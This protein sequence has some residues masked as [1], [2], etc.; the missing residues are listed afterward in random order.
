MKKMYLLASAALVALS[1][2]AKDL[3]LEEYFEYEAGSKLIADTTTG[4]DNLDGET[5]WSTVSN[6]N[7]GM[8]RFTITDAP[9][10]YEGY[11]GSGI[12]NALAF[13]PQ[14]QSGQ[15]V[16][17][18]WGHGVINDTTIYIAFLIQ[19]PKQD[20]NYDGS[21]YFMG[22][23]MEPSATS[24][25]FAGRLMAAVEAKD[26]ITGTPYTGQ[27]ISFGINKSSDGKAVWTNP[28]QKPYFTFDKTYLVV[29]KYH[30]GVINGKT[31]AEEKGNYDDEMW[32]YINP[33]LAAEP[34]EANLYQKDPDAKDAYRM[35]GS[36]KE[37]GSLRGFY[38]RGGEPGKANV[39]APYIIDGIRVGYAWEDVIGKQTALDATRT[40]GKA[41]KSIE[42]GQLVIRRGENKFSVLGT[43][44]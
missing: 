24:T 10:T 26:E 33:T 9:L 25:N 13:N 32:L 27:E 42:N 40:S 30:V 12:G 16:F 15:S 8:T 7:S 11:A 22:I 4:S 31:A 41:H 1:L 36:G 23:K 39:L 38:L 18:N 3:L 2:N 19:F 29:L 44:L 21:D 20:V 35:S 17:K 5:G 14:S 34:A 6:K 28:D 37:M 43:R